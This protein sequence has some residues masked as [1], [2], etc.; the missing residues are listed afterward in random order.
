MSAPVQAVDPAQMRTPV[1]NSLTPSSTFESPLATEGRTRRGKKSRKEPEED[2]PIPE[3]H[4][5][6]LLFF[7][8]HREASREWSGPSWTFPTD[9]HSIPQTDVEKQNWVRLLVD[10]FNNRE[11][12]MD[13]TTGPVINARWLKKDENGNY[14]SYYGEHTIER[15]CWEMVVSMPFHFRI[16]VLT[17]V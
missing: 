1:R 14:I 12:I 9:D 11:D 7:N 17:C 10:A 3:R 13:K 4:S 16:P 2:S 5:D 6:T 8:S 15:V